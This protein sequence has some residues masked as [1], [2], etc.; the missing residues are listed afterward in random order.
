MGMRICFHLYLE[1]YLMDYNR[2]IDSD[3]RKN[4]RIILA[5]SEHYI[6]VSE[7]EDCYLMFKD[8]SRGSV[9]VG[10]FYGDAEFALIDRNERFVVTGGCGIVIYFLR[11]PWEDYS[12]DKQTDQWI[13]LG[14]G[15][16]DIYYD[17]VRQISDTA[18]EITDADGNIS[19]YDVFSR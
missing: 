14:I 17:A 2:S 12:V 7:Y 18:I 19:T 5:E 16:T 4:M 9:S 15:D 1:C 8:R 11:E 10:T 13:E 3:K 6:V